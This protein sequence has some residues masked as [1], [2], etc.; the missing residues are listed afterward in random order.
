MKF[1]KVVSLVLATVMIVGICSACDTQ[2]KEE[3]GKVSIKIGYWPNKDDYPDGYALYEKYLKT[4]KERYPDITIVP[5]SFEYTPENF[6]TTAAAGQIPNLFRVPFTEVPKIVNAGYAADLTSKMKELGYDKALKDSISN[7]IMVDGK[8]YGVPFSAY[9]IGMLYN[10]DLFK[11]AGLVDADDRPIYPK[12]FDELRDTAVTIKE[13]TGK[14]GFVIPTVDAHGGWMLM[15]MAWSFGVDFMEQIDG[16]WKATF[17][18]PEMVN[19]L[20]YI[21]DLKWKYDVLPENVLI[22]RND[23]FQLFGTDQVAM[24]YAAGDWP[25]AMISSYNLSKDSI[26]NSPV[27]AGPGGACSLVGGD[28]WMISPDSTPEQIDAIFKWLD[29]KGE[30]LTLDEEAIAKI[31]EGYKNSYD[32][33]LSVTNEEFTI[34][35]E[36]E[37]DN[38]IKD[39]KAEYLNV[40]DKIWNTAYSDDIELKTEEPSCA[41]E[42]YGVLSPML[43]EVLT[44]RDTDISA[45]VKRANDNFQRDFLDKNN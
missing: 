6:L 14:A 28:I 3:N 22:G 17:D 37:R 20:Q 21:S 40:N 4:M 36:A 26:S 8:Y 23:E 44:N 41:Q 24:M 33:N 30:A 27:P 9:I 45:L 42:L 10:V 15:S 29:V 5:D 35:K 31:K 1:K 39:A 16:K 12:N 32:K 11:E 34:F 18:S 7:L 2:K 43:Q 13:K 19:L 25:N 38:Q